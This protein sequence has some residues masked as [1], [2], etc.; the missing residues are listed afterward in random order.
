MG[1][2]LGKAGR[3]AVGIRFLWA[4]WRTRWASQPAAQKAI[5]GARATVSLRPCSGT[6]AR[7]E[8]RAT[9]HARACTRPPTIA[10]RARPG[11]LGAWRAGGAH[12]RLQLAVRRGQRCARAGGG[13]GGRAARRARRASGVRALRGLA[14]LAVAVPSGRRVAA[15]ESLAGSRRRGDRAEGKA[16]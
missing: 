8:R 14:Y 1:E 6:A 15:R 13:L 7:I 16:V 3:W 11:A 2:R 5:L 10:A 9:Q 12:G 4:E